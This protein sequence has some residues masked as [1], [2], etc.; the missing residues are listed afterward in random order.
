M[1]GRL[2]L[3]FAV[4][5]MLAGQQSTRAP[6]F[7]SGVSLVYVDAAVLD[8]T[9][10][11]IHGLSA[12]D[13]TI[14]EDGAE[15]PISALTEVSA[16]DFDPAA[17]AWQRTVAP[18]VVDNSE[19]GRIIILLFD[20]AQILAERSGQYD[21][22]E[23]TRHIKE[24][25]HAV[26]DRMGPD[27]LTA[28]LFTNQKSHVQDFTSDR[29]KL[30]AAIE[31]FA[32]SQMPLLYIDW[33]RSTAGAL[34]KVA[35]FMASAPPGRKSVIWISPGASGLRVN[36]ADARRPSTAQHV[37]GRISGGDSNQEIG[38]EN[39]A[40]ATTMADNALKS[41]DRGGVTVY[42][43]SPTS[44]TQEIGDDAVPLDD[45]QD[46]NG[47]RLFASA[48]V[49]DTG[50]I[51][52]GSGRQFVA[53]L[54]QIFRETGSYYVLG[55]EP[56]Q[57]T[58]KNDFRRI[59]VRVNR[60]GAIVRARRGYFTA[61]TEK[62]AAPSNAAIAAVLPSS[63]LLLRASAVALPSDHGPATALVTIG[64]RQRQPAGVKT[65]RAL[66]SV[67]AYSERGDRRGEVAGTA[68]VAFRS[69]DGTDTASYNIRASMSLKPGLYELRIAVS[70]DAA[71]Q[72]G[73]VYV[74]VDVPDFGARGV[75]LSQVVLAADRERG[76]A[77]TGAAGLVPVVPTLDR[78]FSPADHVTAFARLTAGKDTRA[79]AIVV[80]SRLTDAANRIVEA[81]EDSLNA[82]KP[83]V[84]DWKRELPLESLTPGP[85]LLTVEASDGHT[86][87]RR[88]I[89]FAVTARSVRRP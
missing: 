67:H 75:N 77:T 72:T 25:G 17:P 84:L 8:E 37:N 13:F 40:I 73:S 85:Y 56:P 55:Y 60:P 39:A 66:W 47:P 32:P 53:G 36:D 51:T 58:A 18:D 61:K 78:A 64:V 22:N 2:A 57:S 81:R 7:R 79:R 11:P 29:E 10:R 76:G 20:D 28:V 5:L 63:A 33:R 82:E 49:E 46:R 50:G 26:V 19:R 9:R 86:T 65:D 34:D 62:P 31:G 43:I 3:G 41:A 6:Q 80:T 54:Q 15:R 30:M 27:D 74:H 16:R 1:L 24:I 88:E 69:V 45:P 12:A 89:P 83:G 71:R 87:V 52:I 14:F 38:N 68:D 70:S 48:L 42:R 59:E 35:A 44:F 23:M 21:P 4:T